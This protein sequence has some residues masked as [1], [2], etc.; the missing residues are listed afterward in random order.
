L[1]GGGAVARGDALEAGAAALVGRAR[2]DDVRGIGAVGDLAQVGRAADGAVGRGVVRGAVA[3]EVRR[4]GLRG[5][6]G[7]RF[8]GDEARVVGAGVV[9]GVARGAAVRAA[10]AGG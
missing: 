3:D 7:A 9:A 5:V 1:V 2:R 8:D 4:V 10:V 6:R